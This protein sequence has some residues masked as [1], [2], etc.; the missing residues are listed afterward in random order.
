MEPRGAGREADCPASL[1]PVEGMSEARRTN[2][3]LFSSV[4]FT[5]FVY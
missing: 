1:K 4:C 3:A 5:V 2:W